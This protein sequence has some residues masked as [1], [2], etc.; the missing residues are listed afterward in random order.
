MRLTIQKGLLRILLDKIDE[1]YLSRSQPYLAVMH[2]TIT[3]T[4]YY[5][6]LHIGEV[7][8][9]DHPINVHDIFESRRSNKVLYCLEP[10]KH[11]E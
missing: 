6:L 4:A 10:P 9:G 8:M 11:M 1:Y 5:G 7:T 3:T 2:K